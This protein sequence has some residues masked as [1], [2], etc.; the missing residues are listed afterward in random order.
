MD[1]VGRL[2]ERVTGLSLGDYFQTHI[3]APL[4]LKHISFIP[5]AE[6]KKNLAGFHQRGTDGV[7]RLRE[8]GHPLHR[9]LTVTSP[10]AARNIIHAGGHGIFCVVS[11]YTGML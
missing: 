11:E 3:F 7:V 6:M 5:S 1:W 9:P 4:G 8:D 2:I 10:E